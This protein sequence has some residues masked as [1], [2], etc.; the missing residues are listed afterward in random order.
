ME[1]THHLHHTKRRFIVFVVLLVLFVLIGTLSSAPKH[2]AAP[3]ATTQTSCYI[4]NT[5][6]GDKATLT[7]TV[8]GAVATGSI[9]FLPAEKDS[10]RGDFT[11][12]IS[13]EK[14]TRGNRTVHA[15]WNAAAEGSVT[16]EE[17]LITVGDSIASV[18]F[19]AMKAQSDG[20]YIYADTTALT[21][22]P[23]LQKTDCTD[24]AVQ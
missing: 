12:V 2:V 16:K 3:V 13:L 22:Q 1:D 10:K 17:V 14:D 23:A 8:D 21:Y 18:G 9:A 15:W 24:P 7:L 19:G 11:G 4:W 6:A 20:S 5:E